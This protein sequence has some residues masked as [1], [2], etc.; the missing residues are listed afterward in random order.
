M[1][2]HP[3]ALELIDRLHEKDHARVVDF[4]S[5]RG[6][7]TQALVE[8]GFE[9]IAISDE[10]A[11]DRSALDGPAGSFDAVLT[12]HALLHGTPQSVAER[13]DAVARALREEG[14]LY[15]TFASVRDA[16]YGKGERLADATFAPSDGDERGVPHVYFDEPS[17]RAIVAPNFTI[18]SLEERDADRIAGTWAHPHTPLR[19]AVHWLLRA[20]R[21]PSAC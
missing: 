18:E 19:G 10:D 6:R 2:A 12:T 4:G 1:P 13:L 5:G 20:V 3:L 16:R 8:A 11:S 9:V 21:V 17:L 14:L 7:N 15:A